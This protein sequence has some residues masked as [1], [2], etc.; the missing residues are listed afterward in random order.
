[1]DLTTLIDTA[2]SENNT[3][4]NYSLF[5]QICE[6]SESDSG[7][8][9]CSI[10]LKRLAHKNINV[11]LNSLTLANSLFLN[12]S[13]SV[14]RQVA[15][16]PFL[17]PLVK[18]VMSDSTHSTIK[19]RILD[20]LSTWNDLAKYDSSMGYLVDLYSNLKQQGIVFPTSKPVVSK[21]I[22]NKEDEELELALALSLSNIND[23]PISRAP[24]TKNPPPLFLVKALYDFPGSEDGEL[25]LSKGDI[26]KVYDDS[27]FRDWWRGSIDSKSGIF[28][29]N[30]VEKVSD[31][32]QVSDGI[33]SL[34]NEFA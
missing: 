7:K 11:T 8:Q 32:K 3:S 29:S 9:T 5:I 33:D 19:S 18:M 24:K 20:L 2:T 1:M 15:S 13:D 27:T 17:D 31:S 4:V 10:L 25:R 21:P 6:S 12:C 14:K 26:V 28:P 22:L 23:K 30:Y 16:R 34:E